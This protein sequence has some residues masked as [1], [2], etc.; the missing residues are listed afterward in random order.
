MHTSLCFVKALHVIVTIIRSVAKGIQ[1]NQVQRHPIN[2]NHP[3]PNLS[4]EQRVECTSHT[5]CNGSIPQTRIFF[6][7]KYPQH[8]FLRKGSKAI[9][10]MSQICGMLKNPVITWKLGHMQNSPAISRPISSLANRLSDACV[11]WSASGV[12]GRN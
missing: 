7:R 6:G 11:A 4:L 8:A 12:D 10:P 3:V 2:M 9:C 1:W 5:T